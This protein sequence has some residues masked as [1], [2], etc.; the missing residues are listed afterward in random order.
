MQLRKTG[1]VEL[2]TARL[3]MRRFTLDDAQAMFDN[4]AGD[5]EVTK[6]LTWP[7]HTSVDITKTVIKSWI[8]RYEDGACFNWAIEL[9][10]SRQAIG[11]IAVVSLDEAI[12]AADLGYCLGKAYW[13]QGIMTEALKTVIDYLFDTVGLNRVAAYHDVS[14]PRSGRVME[15]AGMKFE[16]V[17]RQA[18]R[19]NSGI[20]D[21]AYRSVIRSDRT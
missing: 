2:E 19:N 16:G 8:D 4:W 14:N 9:K 11:S 6:Y 1:T 15:K 10:S 21:I 3:R 12:A 7:T 18:S 13:D 17:L 20:C 5:P